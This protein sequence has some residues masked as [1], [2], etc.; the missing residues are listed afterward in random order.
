MEDIREKITLAEVPI[1]DDGK[2]EFYIGMIQMIC[3]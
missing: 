3:H 1:S 2:D